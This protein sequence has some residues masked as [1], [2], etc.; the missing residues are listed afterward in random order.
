M[1][2]SIFPKFAMI[3]KFADPAITI[4]PGNTTTGIY[5]E[6]SYPKE[7]LIHPWHGAGVMPWRSVYQS[8]VISSKNSKMYLTDHDGTDRTITLTNAQYTGAGLAAEMQTQLNAAGAT[9]VTP[10]VFTV[11]YTPVTA[12]TELPGIFT[13][14]SDST[15]VYR[16]NAVDGSLTNAVWATIGIDCVAGTSAALLTLSTGTGATGAQPNGVK[17]TFGRFIVKVSNDGFTINGT[18]FNIPTGAYNAKTLASVIR[19]GICDNLNVTAVD[20]QYDESTHK[21]KFKN[22]TG[23][24]WTIHGDTMEAGDLIGQTADLSVAS[25]AQYH[26]CAAVRIHTSEEIVFDH[27]NGLAFD[28]MRI[29]SAWGNWSTS[30]NVKFYANDLQLGSETD[31]DWTGASWDIGP[32]TIY[33]T[34]RIVI[35]GKSAAIFLGDSYVAEPNYRYIRIEIEDKAHDVDYVEVG[36]IFGGAYW[37]MDHGIKYGDQEYTIT[38]FS[39]V[40]MGPQANKAGV[41]L[42]A[43]YTTRIAF[44]NMELADKGTLEELRDYCRTFIPFLYMEDTSTEANQMASKWMTL[45]EIFTIKE[46]PGIDYYSAGPF[47]MT[48][49]A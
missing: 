25:D 29:L 13:V 19:V 45:N 20:V 6:I 41:K 14:T 7:Y 33:S 37:D 4:M 39:P 1:V 21:F 9:W 8:F 2:S 26:S 48:E 15:V 44:P 16:Y 3:N 42:T 22:N 23:V 38:D 31:D 46:H 40:V 24:A 49:S 47:S 11:V 10:V 34:T 35:A 17:S 43:P 27:G 28:E 18:S 32:M 5:T 36:L 30:A 12:G